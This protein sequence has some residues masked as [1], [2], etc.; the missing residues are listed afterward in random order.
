MSTLERLQE[1]LHSPS[2][3][4]QIDWDEITA[5]Y[6]TRFPSDYKDFISHYGSGVI[7]D[8]LEVFAPTADTDPYTRRTSR[9]PEDV[10]DL[11]EV[12]E[13]NEPRHAEVYDPSDV[14]VWGETV[15]ADVLGW[16]TNSDTPDDWPVAVYKHGGEWTVF[17]CTMT[18]FLLRL[19][20]GNFERNPTGLTRLFGKGSAQF[21]SS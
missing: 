21:T 3:G 20:T 14:M 10:L 18:E 1:V 5:F 15:E 7:G 8:M 19:L 17:N 6:D 9:I 16:I 2:V 12:N 13:W 11:P 4:T